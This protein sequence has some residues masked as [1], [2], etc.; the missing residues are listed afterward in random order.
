MRIEDLESGQE[1][2]YDCPIG[3]SRGL[4]MFIGDL[5][6]IVDTDLVA[7]QTLSIVDQSTLDTFDVQVIEATAA[8]D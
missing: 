1:V 6:V 4:V 8:H 7:G 5:K 3:P 2:T